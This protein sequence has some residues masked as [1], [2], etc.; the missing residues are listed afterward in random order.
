MLVFNAIL[1]FDAL[2]LGKRAPVSDPEVRP[3][4]D[5]KSR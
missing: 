1:N 2:D 3:G 5:L 4:T